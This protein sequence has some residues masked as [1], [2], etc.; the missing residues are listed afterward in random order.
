MHASPPEAWHAC[1]RRAAHAEARSQALALAH[2][3]S[4]ANPIPC[5][6]APSSGGCVGVRVERR[7]LEGRR[8]A[9]L[10]L[11]L[12][13]ASATPEVALIAALLDRLGPTFDLDQ[14]KSQR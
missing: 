6:G 11:A 13:W 5:P 7:V 3:H 14:V 10:S 4:D 12:V 1:L 8:P 2:N 9:V